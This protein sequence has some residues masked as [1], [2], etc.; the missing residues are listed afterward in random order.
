MKALFR[1]IPESIDNISGL[2][3]KVERYELDR[4]VVLPAFDIPD[5]FKS[6]DEYLRHLTYEGAKE[7]VWN[8]HR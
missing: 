4:D 8:G 5:G 7:A 3:N 1:D 2:I 6:E